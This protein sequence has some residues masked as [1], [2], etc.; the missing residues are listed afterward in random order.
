MTMTA[1][2]T[3]FD[4]QSALPR[5]E[6]WLRYLLVS[7]AATLPLATIAQIPGYLIVFVFGFILVRTRGRAAI[8]MPLMS[9]TIGIFL[10]LAL[11]ASLAGVDPGYSL[12]KMRRFAFLLIIGAMGYAVLNGRNASFDLLRACVIAFLTGLTLHAAFDF[13]RFPVLRSMGVKIFDTGAMTAPQFYLAGLCLAAAMVVTKAWSVRYPPF[14][15]ALLFSMGGLL[16]HFKR[17]AWLS[18]LLMLV[19]MMVCGRKWKMLILVFLIATAFAFLPVVQKRM[20]DLPKEFDITRGG[21]AH[22]MLEVAPAL[23][24]AHPFGM[25]WRAVKADD[26]KAVSDRVESNRDHVHNNFLQITV[27]LGVAGLI[28]WMAWMGAA[29]WLFF[30]SW[31]FFS[32]G[33]Q[34]F[35]SGLALGA[36]L[37]FAGLLINGL[38]EYN[39]GD[40][41]IFRLMIF[42]IAVAVSLHLKSRRSRSAP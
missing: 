5:L 21:R 29:L 30:K 19:L 41:E 7:F 14:A 38:G 12:G 32:S 4:D 31:R 17:G 16:I 26:F 3:A 27:E 23:I 34:S 42:L 8:S 2:G 20:S 35:E 22:M 24:K 40:S 11:V 33:N 28:A 1:A 37:A 36:M 9:W 10:V 25:G 15:V 13:I 39:F 6:Q 18:A